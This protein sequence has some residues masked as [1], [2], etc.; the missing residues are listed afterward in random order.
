MLQVTKSCLF[1]Q[2][3]QQPSKFQE[4][5]S[6]FSTVYSSKTMP[7]FWDRLASPLNGPEPSL[8]PSLLL[9]VLLSQQ[10]GAGQP[11]PRGQSEGA[12]CNSWEQ[13]AGLRKVPAEPV[14]VCTPPPPPVAILGPSSGLQFPTRRGR[15]TSFSATA[16]YV[17]DGQS[18]E[19]P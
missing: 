10:G 1:L 14:A 9:A 15:E 18:S 2:S 11:G 5:L 12:A 8:G 7:V 4:F 19:W 6:C 3:G 17:P 13:I 16:I